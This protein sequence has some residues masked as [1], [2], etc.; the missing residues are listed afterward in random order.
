MKPTLLSE[1]IYQILLKHDAPGISRKHTADVIAQHVQYHVNEQVQANTL[2]Q[3]KKI[4]D[5]VSALCVEANASILI[6][7]DGTYNIMCGDSEM[8][9]TVDSKEDVIEILRARITHNIQMSRFDW[10]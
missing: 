7:G 3:Q 1:L 10:M 5:T 4:W 9:T 8:Q 6:L 2:E